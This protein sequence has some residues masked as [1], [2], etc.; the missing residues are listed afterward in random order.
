MSY[1]PNRK[2]EKILLTDEE[3]LAK[4]DTILNGVGVTIIKEMHVT[5][6]ETFHEGE[7][8]TTTVKPYLIV[9]YMEKIIS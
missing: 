9:T 3:D 8:S 4:Y 7:N 5:E 2:T 1:V 6:K